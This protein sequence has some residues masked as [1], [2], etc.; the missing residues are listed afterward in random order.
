MNDAYKRHPGPVGV[1]EIFIEHRFDLRGAIATQIELEVY[2]AARGRHHDRSR[3]LLVARS[4]EALQR[5]NRLS[6]LERTEHHVGHAAIHGDDL[7][8]LIERHDSHPI[9]RRD[10]LPSRR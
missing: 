7:A 9:P 5:A 10:W 8:L 3:G 6:G 1:L 2:R 4:T